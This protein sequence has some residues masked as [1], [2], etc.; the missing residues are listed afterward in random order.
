MVAPT[1]RRSRLPLRLA[2]ATYDWGLHVGI[3]H[4]YI[5]CNDHLLKL[6]TRLGY[7]EHLPRLHLKEYGRV[8]SLRLNITDEY[9]LRAVGSPF[10]AVLQRFQRQQGLIKNTQRDSQP[11]PESIVE[12]FEN[13]RPR[14]LRGRSTRAPVSHASR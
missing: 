2:F 3:K 1:Q 12:A 14:P 9:H 7:S 8:N 5:D 6:F 4:N 13:Y 11:V 10:L